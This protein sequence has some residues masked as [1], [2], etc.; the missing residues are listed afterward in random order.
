MGDSPAAGNA[1]SSIPEEADRVALDAALTAT[2]PLWGDVREHWRVRILSAALKAAEPAILEAEREQADALRLGGMDIEV[3][4]HHVLGE[5]RI[6]RS[7]PAVRELKELYRAGVTAG[8]CI[9][10]RGAE[11]EP[12]AVRAIRDGERANC[13]REIE[14]RQRALERAEVLVATRDR[15]WADALRENE[16]LRNRLMAVDGL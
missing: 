1:A 14:D 2:A 16:Q 6:T 7:V 10:L 9:A 15:Q 11:P 5:L 8:L 12:E 4:V 3:A 13:A